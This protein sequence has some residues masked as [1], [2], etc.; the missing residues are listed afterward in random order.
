MLSLLLG[1]HPAT[2][3]PE[4]TDTSSIALAHSG[5][6]PEITGLTG[7]IA[8]VRRSPDAE[9]REEI[10]FARGLWTDV[11]GDVVNLA[12]CLFAGDLCTR[13][14]GAP[15]DELVSDPLDFFSYAELVD[16]HDD[17]QVGDTTLRAR[18]DY[19]VPIYMGDPPGWPGSTDVS[20]DGELAAYVGTDVFSY[21]SDV[22]LISPDPVARVALS[23]TEPLALR[24]T[25]G[26]EGELFLRAGD[27]QWHLADDGETSFT[28]EQ[29]GLV[30]PIDV[31]SVVLSRK[32]TTALDASGNQ[33]WLQTSV[34]QALFVDYRDDGGW[35]GLS[36]GVGLGEDCAGALQQPSL[37]AGRYVGDSRTATDDHDLGYGNALTGW[38]T[39]GRDLAFRV[40]LAAGAQLALTYAQ[41]DAD[42]S[43]YV[44]DDGCDPLGA[45]AA[46][47]DELEGDP[48]V[49]V[50]TAPAAAS[51]VIVLDAFSDGA[52]WWLETALP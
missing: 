27:R 29:L 16:V 2:T 43:V 5:Q 41:T 19:T 38:P 1:C 33:V 49:L 20:W 21:A 17:L 40:D 42:A 52:T 18:F 14:L 12:A 24:W 32:T 23:G 6:D 50:F 15:G 22:A 26:S 36:V 30:A 11:D 3:A 8:L 37:P 47:D 34:D 4:P 51:Y 39:R 44:L 9:D 31:V 46:A 28:A 7:S 25:P 13:D 45:L 35:T 48:E 10:R